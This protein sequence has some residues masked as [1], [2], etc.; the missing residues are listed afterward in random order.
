MVERRMHNNNPNKRLQEI[1]SDDSFEL[2]GVGMSR[3]IKADAE[4]KPNKPPK[5]L[6][7]PLSEFQKWAR[8]WQENDPLPIVPPGKKLIL[9]VFPGT[10]RDKNNFFVD[11][12]PERIKSINEIGLMESKS[13]LGQAI[14]AMPGVSRLI[15]MV[16][17]QRGIIVDDQGKLRCPAGTPAANQ[18]TDL[19]MSNCMV[20]SAQTLAGDAADVVGRAIRGAVGGGRTNVNFGDR[21]KTDPGKSIY[22]A[23]EAARRFLSF[24]KRHA[25]QKKVVTRAF[26]NVRDPISARKALLAAFPNMDE[27]SIKKFL[28][29]DG[30]LSGQELLDYIDAREAF[31]TSLLYEAMKNPE[32]AKAKIVWLWQEQLGEDGDDGF[33]ISVTTDSNQPFVAFEYN[34]RLFMMNKYRFDDD[35]DE[36]RDWLAMGHGNDPDEIMSATDYGTYV[37]GHEFGHLADFYTRFKR[38]GLDV[39]ET[40]YKKSI[41]N[42]EYLSMKLGKTVDQLHN[43]GDI[44]DEER[45]LHALFEQLVADVRAAQTP[46]QADDAFKNFYDQLAGAILDS[47]G[48]DQETSDI[49]AD[50]VGSG[51]ANIGKT[52]E[53]H[54]EA[55]KAFS[56]IPE[57]IQRRIDA[58]N[59]DRQRNNEPPIPNVNELSVAMFGVDVTGI[60]P[61]DDINTPSRPNFVRRVT[62]AVRAGRDPQG[63]RDAAAANLDTI[64]DSVVDEF[65]K[66]TE[67]NLL[68]ASE[69]KRDE[70]RKTV[71]DQLFM[72]YSPDEIQQLLAQIPKSQQGNP[73]YIA[74][75][76][77]V[78]NKIARLRTPNNQMHS[79]ERQWNQLLAMAL[80]NDWIDFT[81]ITDAH[82]LRGGEG[83]IRTIRAN[84]REQRR[85]IDKAR[86]QRAARRQAAASARRL[87]GSM[88]ASAKPSYPREPTYGAFIGS[89]ADIFDGVTTWEEFA[90]RYK[91]KEII[92]FDYET[93]GLE[94]DE[95]RET[96]SKGK[97]VQFGAVKIKDGKVVGRINL[98]MNP[99]QQL[100]EWSRNNLKDADGNP[101][102]D[103]WLGQQMSIDEAHRQL[104][105]FA[106]PEAIFGVQNASF[107]K[108]V[109]DGVLREAGIDWSPSGYLDTREIASL[110]L[111]RW[112]PETNDGPHVVD[113]EGNKKPSSSLAAITEY[114]GVEL[115]DGHHNADVDAEATAQVMQKIIDGA[116]E[117]GW[118]KDALDRPK[119]DKINKDAV[120]K[121]NT[122]LAE[123][124]QAKTRYLSGSM[125]PGRQRSIE[126]N[127][128]I[129]EEVAG[130]TGFYSQ[131]LLTGDQTDNI[132]KSVTPEVVKSYKDSVSQ[133]TNLPDDRRARLKQVIETDGVATVRNNQLLLA[134]LFGEQAVKEQIT[135]RDGVATYNPYFGPGLALMIEREIAIAEGDTDKLKKIDAFIYYINNATPEQMAQDIIE[136]ANDFGDGFDRRISV[137]VAQ[138][139]TFIDSGVYYTQHN[140]D[141]RQQLGIRS[142]TGGGSD[143]RGPRRNAESTYGFP[144]DVG[145][146]LRPA[147]GVLQQRGLAN[148][149]RR[150][151]REIYGDDVELTENLTI[152][153]DVDN[154]TTAD[155][156]YGGAGRFGAT[157][158]AGRIILKP[159]IAERSRFTSSDSMASGGSS[160]V[161]VASSESLRFGGVASTFAKGDSINLLYHSMVDDGLSLLS[162]ASGTGTN[163]Y[164]EALIPGSFDMDDVE[165]I[166]VD[167]EQIGRLDREV[168]ASIREDGRMSLGILNRSIEND[169]REFAEFVAMRA[170]LMDKHDATIVL[171]SSRLGGVDG[172]ELFNPQMTERFVTGV[173]PESFPYISKDDITPTS[174]VADMILLNHLRALEDGKTTNTSFSPD[175]E[176]QLREAMES[177]DGSKFKQILEAARL[178]TISSLRQTIKNRHGRKISGSM[179]SPGSD[180]WKQRE[181]ERKALVIAS[182]LGQTP[183][184][185]LIQA[186]DKKSSKSMSYEEM[187]DE[188]MRKEWGVRE[189]DDALD[190]FRGAGFKRF[191][192]DDL[193]TA[194]SKSQNNR[195]SGSISIGKV[196]HT[197][198]DV[199]VSRPYL[200]INTLDEDKIGEPT[201]GNKRTDSFPVYTVGSQKLI[202][203]STQLGN[204]IFEFDDDV[205]VVPLNPYVI[206]NTSAATE[207]GR[208]TAMTWWYA[209]IGAV[210]EDEDNAGYASALLYS[211]SRGDKD[212]ERE[213]QRLA[214]A[215]KIHIEN[216][217]QQYVKKVGDA[218]AD[219][220][221][222]RE[223]DEYTRFST[224]KPDGTWDDRVLETSDLFAI[225]QTSYK[226]QIDENGNLILRPL[227]DFGDGRPEGAEGPKRYHRSSLHFSLNHLVEGH[228]GRQSPTGETYAI[229]ASVD[230][231]M[232]NNSDSLDAL[233]AVD[234]V[235]TPKP[236]EGLV[237]PPGS[238]RVVRLPSKKDLGIEDWEPEKGRFNMT[239]EER[240]RD[241][242]ELTTFRNAQQ[243]I[244]DEMLQEL[245]KETHG[246]DYRTK[247]FP[248]GMHG[249]TTDIDWRIRY[250]AS[251]FGVRSMKHVDL[252]IADFEKRSVFTETEM[253]QIRHIADKW[254]MSI[255]SILRLINGDRFTTA[256]TTEQRRSSFLPWD[257]D[258]L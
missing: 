139:Q 90:E 244:I 222:Y 97:P 183:L 255:N 243:K 258:D 88:S 93:T 41:S 215:G 50:L 140:F 172:V 74:T 118:S 247:V 32:A 40:D 204:Q 47:T 105:E 156:G 81:A 78:P 44:T 2:L 141:E 60:Q 217:K 179:G 158:A 8:S 102:T 233:Y 9:D 107:D 127:S 35:P 82:I 238:Y 52:Q 171:N 224:R 186:I 62:N 160:G 239:A 200:P 234:T 111:P 87:S 170:R 77:K 164:N 194:M 101:L 103:E 17:K 34:P 237:F 10:K 157:G 195:I 191:T 125:G 100:G 20:P 53:T 254:D 25:Y 37:G 33:V 153:V 211:A 257:D 134:T 13:V 136:S 221:W 117:K 190:A 29:D 175:V 98:F 80:Q 241:I 45:L 130:Q 181:E 104:A 120:D 166:V 201:D 86:G 227:E 99:G 128:S 21:D 30:D 75:L 64:T 165:A 174:T 84:V 168:G 69:R 110:T 72:H 22:G 212:A 137:F 66:E 182:R 83:P 11:V 55:Y 173:Q 146:R 240:Q 79:A 121:F 198:G 106:G 115:G 31:I 131:D 252:P 208:Q 142:A 248:G 1:L 51:Y 85:I 202:F 144:L 3:E 36:Y 63:D 67:D 253:R 189:I 16:A 196:S 199:A 96:T 46:D 76:L 176:A 108:D 161:S 154:A 230:S 235:F 256:V 6:K 109:L 150:R 232:Q 27:D 135:I 251:L 19:Q 246:P 193:R 220:D 192:A 54:A 197:K 73:A 187:E 38:F 124:R 214:D 18:F 236:G 70:I 203:G 149:R 155:T 68:R 116:I 58:I 42:I 28:A 151:L 178:D 7:K 56:S 218:F 14:G 169:A 23:V 5:K 210:L 43:D 242:D 188:L 122:E 123:F 231:I 207:E 145:P 249:T 15:A 147:S 94:F 229:I 57:I 226:P 159:H 59:A 152:G 39:D 65:I 12:S 4:S 143:V 113:R 112:T 126:A 61:P 228:L 185:H 49:I 163:G 24:K 225:H 206:S 129:M 91:G 162:P 95:F 216:Q 209:T 205:E 114:L 167:A 213:L 223:G 132:R 245:G 133:I 177:S 71:L 89:A 250:L 184:E 119:R 26:G 138:P 180:P 219:K 148:G 48:L 92:F